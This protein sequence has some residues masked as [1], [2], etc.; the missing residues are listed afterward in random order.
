[1][2]FTTVLLA[3]SAMAFELSEPDERAVQVAA[4]S[5]AYGFSVLHAGFMADA[6]FHDRPMH[7]SWTAGTA[8]SAWSIAGIGLGYVTLGAA[9]T[10]NPD[11]AFTL[12]MSGGGHIGLGGLQLAFAIDAGRRGEGTVWMEPGPAVV[13]LIQGTAM[14]G[15]GGVLTLGANPST[16]DLSKINPIYSWTV[17]GAGVSGYAVASLLR[18]R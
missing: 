6:A 17:L 1:M 13:T 9:F 16:T 14:M 10:D 18:R 2:V 7:R 4:M 3:A 11:D 12:G 5:T 15:F 8:L